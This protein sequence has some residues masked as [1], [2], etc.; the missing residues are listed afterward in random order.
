MKLR[1]LLTK[2]NDVVRPPQ[3][4]RQGH[5]P[6]VDAVDGLATM[7]VVDPMGNLGAESA[8]PNWVPSQQDDRPPH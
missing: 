8:P 4:R 2:I 5:R 6:P 7:T 1:A 3:V